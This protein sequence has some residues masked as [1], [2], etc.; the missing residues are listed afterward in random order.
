MATAGRL[1]LIAMAAGNPVFLDWAQLIRDNHFY[2]D[3]ANQSSDLPGCSGF[4]V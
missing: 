3:G 2:T 4:A 1:E